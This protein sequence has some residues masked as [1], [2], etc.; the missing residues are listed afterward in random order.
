M[1]KVNNKNTLLT[2][3]KQV[4]D[5]KYLRFHHP[6]MPLSESLVKQ[7]DSI[8]VFKLPRSILEIT[9]TS[10]KTLKKLNKILT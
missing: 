4:L 7:D 8:S 6:I 3:N 9:K 1:F 10:K 2:L 5:R